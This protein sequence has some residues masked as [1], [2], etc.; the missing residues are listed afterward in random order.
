MW[1]PPSVTVH[2]SHRPKVAHSEYICSSGYPGWPQACPRSEKDNP[3]SRNDAM[4]TEYFDSSTNIHRQQDTNTHTPPTTLPHNLHKSWSLHWSL[5]SGPTCSR[6]QKMRIHFLSPSASSVP[7]EPASW[8]AGA[9][10]GCCMLNSVIISPTTRINK[11]RLSTNCSKSPWLLK[12]S[13]LM[14]VSRSPGAKVFLRMTRNPYMCIPS[15]AA[16]F[17]RSYNIRCWCDTNRV[18]SPRMRQ[19]T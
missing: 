9:E 10:D 12:T 16:A 18:L 2:I 1:H 8:V 4:A 14:T 3:V 6:P 5:S 11:S 19:T 17:C 13:W 7:R 15:C